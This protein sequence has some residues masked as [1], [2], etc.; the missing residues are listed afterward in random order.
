MRHLYSVKE[1]ASLG[2]QSDYLLF[3]IECFWK[4]ATVPADFIFTGSGLQHRE[5][6]WDL[7]KKV[8]GKK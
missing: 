3:S 7:Q 2:V 1:R 8:S 5:L 4:A 6:L